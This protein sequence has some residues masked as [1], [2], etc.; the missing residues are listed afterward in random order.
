MENIEL[1][2]ESLRFAKKSLEKALNSKV[3]RVYIYSTYLEKEI[4]IK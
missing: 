1:D 2:M 4:F 3:D